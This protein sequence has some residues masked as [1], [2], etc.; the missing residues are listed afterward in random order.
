MI[1]R[2]IIGIFLLVTLVMPVFSS[3]VASEL[4][5]ESVR[6]IIDHVI[7]AAK[8]QNSKN[9]ASVFGDKAII[10]SHVSHGEKKKFIKQSKTEYINML[11]TNWQIYDSYFLEASNIAIDFQG[12]KALV[13]SNVK[14]SV[15][16]QEKNIVANTKQQVIIELINETPLITSIVGYT[17]IKE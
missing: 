5:E 6:K 3:V 8:E 12:K 7:S 10:T 4:S 11:D 9:I 16:V 1:N 17:E 2:F 13:T 14:E 15:T